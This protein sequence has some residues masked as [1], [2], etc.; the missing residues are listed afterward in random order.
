MLGDNVFYENAVSES[1]WST[2]APDMQ[3]WFYEHG[4]KPVHSGHLFPNRAGLLT[5]YGSFPDE[6]EAKYREYNLQNPPPNVLGVE[7]YFPPWFTEELTPKY[8][9]E[10]LSPKEITTVLGI[11]EEGQRGSSQPD[12][13]YGLMAQASPK[14]EE[15]LHYLDDVMG[16]TSAMEWKEENFQSDSLSEIMSEHMNQA[17]AE[18][19]GDK[20]ELLE[21]WMNDP[22]TSHLEIEDAPDWSHH[23]NKINPRLGMG[24]FLVESM[25]DPNYRN[26][27]DQQADLGY[28]H[29]PN[30]V[31]ANAARPLVR[32]AGIDEFRKERGG[33]FGDLRIGGLDRELAHSLGVYLNARAREPNGMLSIP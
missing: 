26:W 6:A 11:T 33:G 25:T 13:G 32:Y 2:L 29:N 3:K 27:A 15:Y 30:E 21:S 20:D 10:G 18:R 19:G 23:G 8:E 17:W 7:R 5:T 14:I 1:V 22:R 9:E 28:W 4:V 16:D 12:I 24:K 31:Y